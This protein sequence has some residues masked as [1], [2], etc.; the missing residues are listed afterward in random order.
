MVALVVG[1]GVI[2][3]LIFDHFDSWL[4]LSWREMS[5]YEFTEDVELRDAK[6]TSTSLQGC[7]ARAAG[8]VALAEGNATLFIEVVS[9]SGDERYTHELQYMDGLDWRKPK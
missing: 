9:D 1:L 6:R 3:L 5:A 2:I 4:K 7:A 8:S